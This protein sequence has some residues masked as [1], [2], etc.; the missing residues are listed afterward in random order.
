MIT[1]TE[2]EAPNLRPDTWQQRERACLWFVA[3]FGQGVKVHSIKRPMAAR[4]ANDLQREGLTNR[5]VA[6]Q[7]SHVAQL[8]QALIRSGSLPQGQNP[9]KGLVTLSAADK[10]QSWTHGKALDGAQ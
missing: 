9:V 1:Y 10:R 7:V 4:W 2:V 8:F 6:N 5:Y 3:Y